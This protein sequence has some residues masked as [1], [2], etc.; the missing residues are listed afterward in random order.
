MSKIGS[1]WDLFKGFLTAFV[2]GLIFLFSGISNIP[3]YGQNC[4]LLIQKYFSFLDPSIQEITGQILDIMMIISNFVGSIILA[5]SVL[6]L[7]GKYRISRI[8]L[9]IVMGAG[10]ISFVIPIFASFAGGIDA[11]MASIDH[12]SNRYAVAVLLAM[13]SKLFLAKV[14]MKQK[15]KKIKRNLKEVEKEEN[16]KE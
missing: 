14:T 4:I 6:I 5:A 2:S 8:I 1:F 7:L 16:E 3:I 12:L 15:I 9:I 11:I 10:V 13:I